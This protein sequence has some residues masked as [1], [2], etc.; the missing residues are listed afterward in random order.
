[1]S[2]IY[3]RQRLSNFFMHCHSAKHALQFVLERIFIKSRNREVWEGSD[4]SLTVIGHFLCF[5]QL[6]ILYL[7]IPFPFTMVHLP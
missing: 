1:M 7:S 4:N 5:V 3:L 6:P 2:M